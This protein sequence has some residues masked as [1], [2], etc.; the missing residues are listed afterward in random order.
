MTATKKKKPDV[1]QV[2]TD[3]ILAILD[4]GAC[5]WQKPW[6]GGKDGMPRNLHS[7]KPYRG[8]NVLLLGWEA[9]G[10]GYSSPYWLTYK[11][12]KELGGSVIKG[13]KATTVTFWKLLSKTEEAATGEDKTSS[14]MMLKMYN[15]FNYEQTEGCRI[16]KGREATSEPTEPTAAENAEA[17]KLATATLADYVYRQPG[18]AYSEEDSSKAYY[19]PSRDRIVMPNKAQFKTP[20]HYHAVAFHE[21]GHS[22][23]HKSRLARRNLMDPVKFD[24]HAYGQE[25]LVA[26]F[27]SAFCASWLGVDTSA[28]FENSAAYLASWKKTIRA[29][30]KMVVMAAAQ[31]QKAADLILNIEP[32][33]E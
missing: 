26:E 21:A 30:K 15:V 2:V 19:V 33:K 10:K 31:A 28:V 11:Q 22:T 18:L 6:K 17:D 5:P 24:K 3:S 9:M 7:G 23:G 4:K 16:P 1:Y 20:E 32:T 29:D 14:F 27:T 12:A 8:M 25:E 13:Q